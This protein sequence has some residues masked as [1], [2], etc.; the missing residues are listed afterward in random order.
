MADPKQLF[1]EFG[2]QVVV[3]ECLQSYIIAFNGIDYEVK[4]NDVPKLN[5]VYDIV[6]SQVG[7][8]LLG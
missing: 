4:K 2:N 7:G 1:A 3:A 6:K 8:L 5:E